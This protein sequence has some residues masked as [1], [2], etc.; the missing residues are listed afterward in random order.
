MNLLIPLPLSVGRSHFRTDITIRP[1]QQE[2]GK[3]ERGSSAPPWHS[4]QA[5]DPWARDSLKGRQLFTEQGPVIPRDTKKGVSCVHL[6]FLNQSQSRPPCTSHL[7]L[8][9][10]L[11]ELSTR[12]YPW[13]S[14]SLFKVRILP[15]PSLLSNFRLFSTNSA[16]ADFL[17]SCT[18]VSPYTESLRI[19]QILS[20]ILDSLPGTRWGCH[21]LMFSAL[22]GHLKFNR[23]TAP[24]CW[25][26]SHIKN[27]KNF[28][29]EVE[30][31]APNSPNLGADDTRAVSWKQACLA[32]APRHN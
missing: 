7:F 8:F 6:K 17:S 16:Q 31:S 10:R 5:S 1:Q 12:S 4:K 14:S 18:P 13:V 11:H 32:K 21:F 29:E 20:L 27:A 15:I 19:M 28:N 22:Q 9:L 30:T 25:L 26:Y 23:F 3:R 2:E 24:I